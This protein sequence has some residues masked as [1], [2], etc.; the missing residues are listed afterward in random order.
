MEERRFD[1]LARLVARDLP[2]RRV[3]GGL[4]LG[5]FG[6]HGKSAGEF[7]RPGA[8]GIDVDGFV[9]VVDTHNHRI[10]K[11]IPIW[12]LLNASQRFMDGIV[13]VGTRSA[14]T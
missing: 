2:R 9:Y 8:A 4:F 3:L 6:I 5:E 1:R 10:Q 14:L 11:F 13:S 12:R 7:D